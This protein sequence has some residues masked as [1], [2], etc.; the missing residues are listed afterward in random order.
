MSTTERLDTH[1]CVFTGG[2]L[3]CARHSIDQMLTHE[4]DIMADMIGEADSLEEIRETD[5]RRYLIICRKIL[6]DSPSSL[7]TFTQNITDLYEKDPGE[8]LLSLFDRPEWVRVVSRFSVRFVFE[9]VRNPQSTSSPRPSV[10]EQIIPVHVNTDIPL[11]G[12]QQYFLKT[13][14]GMDPAGYVSRVD[15]CS[16][17]L[18]LSLVI[19]ERTGSSSVKK[20]PSHINIHSLH[21]MTFHTLSDGKVTYQLR[22]IIM[23]Q[24]AGIDSGHYYYILLDEQRRQWAFNDQLREVKEC[25]FEDFTREDCPYLLFYRRVL[26]T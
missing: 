1:Q 14:H 24:G 20:Y 26:T 8:I 17:F 21:R 25:H 15:T 5:I 18:L 10:S 19:F 4:T 9:N 6:D 11:P 12:I 13:I 3:Q 2:S 22:G 16:R 7:S 23:H